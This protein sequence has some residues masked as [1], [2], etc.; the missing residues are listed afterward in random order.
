MQPTAES[1][2]LPPAFIS[3]RS[4]PRPA[5]RRTLRAIT[6][7]LPAALAI[8]VGS[9]M[10]GSVV[11]TVATSSTTQGWEVGAVPAGAPS[12][13]ARVCDLAR[14]SHGH[15]WRNGQTWNA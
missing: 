12:C 1:Q 2:A 10:L 11:G 8:A 13:K 9:V 5:R 4:K 7:A 15:T 14:P 6:I 3:P